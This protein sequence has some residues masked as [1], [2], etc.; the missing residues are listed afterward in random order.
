MT[1]EEALQVFGLS[2][3]MAVTKMEGSEMSGLLVSNAIIEEWFDGDISVGLTEQIRQV[4]ETY[5]TNTIRQA[6][7]VIANKTKL[8]GDVA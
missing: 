1:L 5:G 6:A 3:I 7:R 2:I 4:A 8:Y